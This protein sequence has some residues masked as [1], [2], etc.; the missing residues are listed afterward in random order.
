MHR[1]HYGIFCI[2]RVSYKTK[3][4]KLQP[5]A[6]VWEFSGGGYSDL[7]SLLRLDVYVTL[8]FFAAR[9]SVAYSTFG[10]SDIKGPFSV[11]AGR[12]ADLR[13]YNYITGP[14]TLVVSVDS[15]WP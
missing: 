15:L 9:N 3:M 10:P 7:V 8:H 4:K 12:H 6:V 2:N 14:A 13:R 1:G 5:V 11:S